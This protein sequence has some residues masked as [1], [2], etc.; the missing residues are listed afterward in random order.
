METS[1]AFVTMTAQERAEQVIDRYDKKI[2][3]PPN[4]PP[5]AGY[6]GCRKEY[7]MQQIIDALATARQEERDFWQ[8]RMGQ[9]LDEALQQTIRA[10]RE[11]CAKVAEDCAKWMAEHP[12]RQDFNTIT[13]VA[14]GI[15]TA[16]REGADGTT[17]HRD[18]SPDG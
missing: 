1:K 16:I 8:Q 17:S 3:G 7:L 11:R 18:V 4:H 2:C 15:A 6:C 13:G 10:E 14:R 9:P 5:I 12:E